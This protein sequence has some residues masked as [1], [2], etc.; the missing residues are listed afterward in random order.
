LSVS[1]VLWLM[2]VI[3]ATPEAEMRDVAG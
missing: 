1:W 3:L 2:S